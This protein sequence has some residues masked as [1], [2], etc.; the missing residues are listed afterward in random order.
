MQPV[1]AAARVHPE[2]RTLPHLFSANE[3][4]WRDTGGAQGELVVEKT[5]LG[6]GLVSKRF[7]GWFLGLVSGVRGNSR[8][9]QKPEKR[10]RQRDAAAPETEAAT[11]NVTGRQ[12]RSSTEDESDTGGVRR[13]TRGWAKRRRPR[14]R[15][16]GMLEP[17][18]PA[19]E[20][21]P[22]NVSGLRETFLVGR[23]TT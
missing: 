2:V 5:F 20:T 21:S 6:L 16:A 17:E 14:E 12:K 15:R 1:R 18:K 13:R 4:E 3:F 10:N 9:H 7:W 11:R 8:V 23:S 19:P 22:R